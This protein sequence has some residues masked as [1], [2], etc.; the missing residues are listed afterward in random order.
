MGLGINGTGSKCASLS[1]VRLRAHKRALA[2]S[3]GSAHRDPSAEGIVRVANPLATPTVDE[4]V[5]MTGATLGSGED[6]G[7][8]Q[9]TSHR[10][11]GGGAFPPSP[12]AEPALPVFAVAARRRRAERPWP[13]S[14]SLS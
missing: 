8:P 13:S 5:G 10:L 11:G 1:I 6:P 4:A 14:S 3:S 7:R 9:P 12:L 2:S